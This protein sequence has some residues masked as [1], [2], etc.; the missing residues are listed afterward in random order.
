QKN[1]SAYIDFLNLK[2]AKGQTLINQDLTETPENG[3]SIFIAN[4]ADVIKIFLSEDIKLYKFLSQNEEIRI[5]KIQSLEKESP[6]YLFT[7]AEIR[8]QWAFVKLKMGDELSAMMSLRTSYKLLEENLKLY[9]DFIP[10]K[11]SM[12]LLN[13]IIGSIP[14]NYNWVLS[15]LGMEGNIDKGISQ[16]DEVCKANTPFRLE[17]SVIKIIVENYITHADKGNFEPIE[18]IHQE[19]P[20]NILISYLYA[21][22]LTKAS[23]GADALQIMKNCSKSSDIIYFPQIDLLKGELYLCE[24]NYQATRL[25]LTNFLSHFKGKNSIKDTYFKLFLTHWLS[26]EDEI[27]MTYFE[28]ILKN[29]QELYDSDKHA[30]KVAKNREIPNKMITKI[31]L[32]TDG[33]YYH[34]AFD[35]LKLISLGQFFTK[36]DKLEYL[37]RSAR[38]YHKS[39]QI[40]DA[41]VYY[42]KTIELSKNENY[43]FAPNSALQLGYIYLTR[44]EKEEAKKQFV[45]ALSYKNYDYKNSIDNKAKAALNELKE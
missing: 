14:S 29:G 13:V 40:N 17:A 20:E 25:H 34:K 8:L 6:Y 3:I 37:Y 45:H 12:G 31:R 2:I 28:K 16:L 36:R 30:E 33:G 22:I 4:Y 42:T 32:Y 11:K 21:A 19:H 24:G 44:N 18:S 38:L 9:P 43:Y 27:A 1:E 39:G 7:Q 41:I 23:R 26:N 5:K 10:T 15:L 35:L